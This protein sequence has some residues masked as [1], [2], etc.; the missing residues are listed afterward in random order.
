M[1]FFVYIIESPSNEDIENGRIEG[2]VLT[3]YFKLGGDIPYSYNFVTNRGQLAEALTSHLIQACENFQGIPILHFSMHGSKGGIH[4]TNDFI[5][6]H[7]LRILLLPLLQELNI[8]LIIC[9]STCFGIHGCQMAMYLDNK[10]S[11]YALIGNNT[12]VSFK[13]AI[14]AYQSF[15]HRLFKGGTTFHDCVEAMKSASGNNNFD[16]VLGENIRQYIYLESIKRQAL[17]VALQRMK[18]ATLGMRNMAFMGDFA[19]NS[20]YQQRLLR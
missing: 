5:S 3:E 15:Y 1:N 2:K 19:N 10:P 12:K 9:M 8:F 18:N 17:N 16:Y 4:L 14:M 20:S 7:E 13:D 6:W 11:F